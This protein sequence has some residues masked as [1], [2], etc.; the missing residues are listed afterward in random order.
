MQMP[1]TG[2]TPAR[3]RTHRM[4]PTAL[5]GS[6]GPFVMKSASGFAAITSSGATVCGKT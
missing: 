5:L 4:A 6:P 1:M 3:S 2:T